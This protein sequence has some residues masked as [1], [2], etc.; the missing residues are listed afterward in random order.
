[1]SPALSPLVPL[2][3]VALVFFGLK[4]VSRTLFRWWETHLK[5][6]YLDR[7]GPPLPLRSLAGTVLTLAPS[8]GLLFLDSLTDLAVLDLGRASRLSL[9]VFGGSA[10]LLWFLSLSF[11]G[12]GLTL[13]AWGLALVSVPF[14]QAFDASRNGWGDFL[15][16]WALMALGLGV[17]HDPRNWIFLDDLASSVN[18]VSSPTWLPPM[19]SWASGVA[20]GALFR[21]PLGPGLTAMVLGAQ[22]VFPPLES[23]LFLGGSFLGAAL[24]PTLAFRHQRAEGRSLCLIQVQSFLVLSLIA[25]AT[26]PAGAAL[27][28]WALLETTSVLPFL[29][30]G[31]ASLVSLLG[32]ASLWPLL[33][34]L[35]RVARAV[36]SRV[37]FSTSSPLLSHSVESNIIAYRKLAAQLLEGTYTMLLCLMDV[38]Q[39]PKLKREVAERMEVAV[40]DFRRKLASF[41]NDLAQ[42]I[43]YQTT[44][45]QAREL[46]LLQSIAVNCELVALHLQRIHRIVFKHIG[47]EGFYFRKVIRRLYRLLSYLLDI[48]RYNQGRLL[49]EDW[50]QEVP[51]V[52]EIEEAVHRLR[53]RIKAAIRKLLQKKS[54]RTVPPLIAQ[55]EV[56]ELL[57]RVAHQER[58]LGDLIAQLNEKAPGPGPGAQEGFSREGQPPRT[59]KAPS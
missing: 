34:A 4:S 24:H 32:L 33:P 18:P 26:A 42:S 30:A 23:F 44:R 47:H 9:G 51:V 6:W 7:A 54:S 25:T 2:G 35:T 1:M 13:P 39:S 40:E 17:L 57:H 21:S 15:M 58:I 22:G 14:F 8:S 48:E 36:S 41:Q 55:L 52:E 31:F 3:A 11:L 10:A 46:Q 12:E 59:T 5:H 37:V 19:L 27:V 53:R 28:R 43:L 38:S 20:A 16:G 56:L 29:L 45:H 49:Q 50:I